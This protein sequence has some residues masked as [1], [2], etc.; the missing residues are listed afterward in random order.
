M[1]TTSLLLSAGAILPYNLMKTI[2]RYNLMKTI[3]WLNLMKLYVFQIVGK[4]AFEPQASRWH[5]R[6]DNSTAMN[7]KRVV[8]KVNSDVNIMD[9]K[10][11]MGQFEGNEYEEGRSKG[12][13]GCEYHGSKASD[14][15]IRRQ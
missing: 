3:L 10:P 13:F 2:L 1:C 8:R 12:K 6:W 11:L 9:Q 7:I 4:C 5:L 14:G 15:T